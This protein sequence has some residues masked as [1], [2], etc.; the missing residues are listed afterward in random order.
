MDVTFPNR[1]PPGILHRA[2]RAP[3]PLPTAA[4]RESLT[5]K[6][7]A[8]NLPPMSPLSCDRGPDVAMRVTWGQQGPLSTLT[9]GRGPP[10][11]T[12]TAGASDI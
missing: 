8:E 5:L 6:W 12:K 9:S 2:V 10:I 3:M 4:D 7:S 1:L 11:N